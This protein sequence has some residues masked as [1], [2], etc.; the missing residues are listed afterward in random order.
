[1]ISPLRNT[2]PGWRSGRLFVLAQPEYGAQGI[3]ANAVLPGGT[4]PLMG[5]MVLTSP[6][7]RTFVENMHALKRLGACTA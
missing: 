7:M 1:M 3:R 2:D 5:R 4:D 6:E